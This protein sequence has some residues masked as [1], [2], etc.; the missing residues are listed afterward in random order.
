M[1]YFVDVLYSLSTGQTRKR[2]DDG[3]LMRS[4]RL[5][6]TRM[7]SRSS[8]LNLLKFFL[9]VVE[10]FLSFGPRLMIVDESWRKFS[11]ALIN[12][13]PHLARAFNIQ[14]VTYP[15]N[16]LSI[17]HSSVIVH[18][19]ADSD[20]QIDSQTRHDKESNEDHARQYIALRRRVISHFTLDKHSTIFNLQ[21]QL[22]LNPS[23]TRWHAL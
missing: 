1:I 16:C 3:T 7:R 9:G 20:I 18:H 14:W 8:N 21:S 6:W 15:T 10:S 12:S 23:R 17:H 13:H 4:H 11:W 5:S 19:G 22:Y 2:V